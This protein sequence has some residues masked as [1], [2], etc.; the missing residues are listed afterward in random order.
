MQNHQSNFVISTYL[1]SRVYSVIA[2]VLFVIAAH[3]LFSFLR[4][5][6]GNSRACG[7]PI[8][9]SIG[10]P[11][12]QTLFLSFP[13]RRRKIIPQINWNKQNKETSQTKVID[14]SIIDFLIQSSNIKIDTHSYV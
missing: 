10:V 11:F 13:R 4:R 1:I 12:L 5:Q 6:N 14:D 8:Q 7:N 9:T 3:T 2:A